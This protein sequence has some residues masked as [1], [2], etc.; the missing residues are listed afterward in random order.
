MK[1]ILDD[2]QFKA[3]TRSLFH[4]QKKRAGGYLDFTLDVLRIRLAGALGTRPLCR[5]CN[6]LNCQT[7]RETI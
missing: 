4:H 1:T 6:A 3:R 2:S 5:Y 7:R